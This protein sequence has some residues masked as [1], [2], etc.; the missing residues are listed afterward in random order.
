MAVANGVEKARLVLHHPLPSRETAIVVEEVYSILERAVAL[1]PTLLLLVCMLSLLSS[2]FLIT[3]H[4]A[5]VIRY[6]GYQ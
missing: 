1:D 5:V 2:T 3:K 4:K 6:A